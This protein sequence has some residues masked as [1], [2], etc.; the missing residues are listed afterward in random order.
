MV[1]IFEIREVEKQEIEQHL[2]V[3]KIDYNI[4]ED[5]LTYMRNNPLF[6]RREYFPTIED[7]K[8]SR[9]TKSLMPMIRKGLHAYCDEY[10]LPH[11]RNK[12]LG[13]G[14]IDEIITAIMRDDLTEGISHLFKRATS[15]DPQFKAWY[16]VY[17]ENPQKAERMV[18]K[19]KH[20]EYVE[21]Y[22]G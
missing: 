21:K 4:A 10:K 19:A 7:F 13:H 1:K 3:P 9:N 20:A 6:Y 15:A 18:G 2:E 22:V 12:L 11:D 17:Q 16:K 8:Q 14:D 5:L